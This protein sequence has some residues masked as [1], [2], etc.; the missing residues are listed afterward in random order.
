MIRYS[1]MTHTSH[2]YS[3]QKK[4][5]GFTLIELVMV[6]VI[7]GVIAGFSTQFVVTAVKSFASVS[8]KNTLLSRSR[9][10]MDYMVRRLRNALP[11]SVITTNDNAC[12]VF[13]P[14]V[15]SGLYV[16]TLPSVVNGAFAIG[17]ITPINVSPFTGSGGDSDYLVIAANNSSEL[18]G[19]F[20][21][22]LA[23]IESTT[24][25]TITLLEDKQWLR[26]SINQRFYV[27]DNPKAFCITDDELRLYRNV[28]ITDSSVDTSD[29][30][31]L[32]SHSVSAFSQAFSISS[33]VEDRN[34]RITLSLLFT[35]ADNR[36]ESVK[37]VVVRN[38]P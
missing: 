32:L 13:M 18:Y 26:N 30:Y 4:H 12:L 19:L 29:D 24:I 21:G 17:S 38:V 27:V 7:L 35:D 11:Y 22:S 15:A 6:I 36:I 16:D 9:L 10:S 3:H 8:S 31:D 25:N 34:I 33:A 23:A 14:I 28:S 2:T 37:Q 5:Q 1:S 20:P